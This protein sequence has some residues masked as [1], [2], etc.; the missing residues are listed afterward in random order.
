M[1]NMAA[2]Q[3]DRQQPPC[4]PPQP[5]AML[6]WRYD[7]REDQNCNPKD[8]LHR[9]NLMLLVPRSLMMQRS[10]RC[11]S[12]QDF[13]R[14]LKTFQSQLEPLSEVALDALWRRIPDGTPL[15]QIVIEDRE[16]RF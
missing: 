5:Y 14:R 11:C 7:Y 13:R 8:S 6:S 10:M 4:S 3:E 16:K 12:L 2:Y 1:G 9:R 15:S